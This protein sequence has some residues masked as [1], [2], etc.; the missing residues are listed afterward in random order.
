MRSTVRVLL[1]NALIALP[2]SLVA[3]CGG[4]GNVGPGSPV[5]VG[6]PI[7]PDHSGQYHLGPV[8]FQESEW[9]N[10]CAPYPS[11][12][13]T[14]TGNMIAGVSNTIAAPGS[15]CDACIEVTTAM[16]KT[17]VLRVVTYGVSGSSGDLDVSP[18]AFEA[19]NLDEF[20]RTMSWH[21]VACDN[22]EPLYVQFQTSASQWWTSFWVRNPTMAIERVEVRNTKFPSGR[23]LERGTDGT[24]TEGSGFGEGPFT[25]RVI[26]VTGAYLDIPMTGV[27]GGALVAAS[28]NIPLD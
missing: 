9:H 11:S 20:P 21:L 8:D 13:R 10:A 23:A 1:R 24:F 27:A 16:G 15:L 2:I 3:S 19:L 6:D 26:G 12:I 14:I 25:I 28:G 7:G 17:E 5:T 18:E 4:G 22:A